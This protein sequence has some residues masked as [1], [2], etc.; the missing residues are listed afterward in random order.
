MKRLEADDS[1]L[2]KSVM[3][4]TGCKIHISEEG[5]MR[6]YRKIGFWGAEEAV[7]KTKRAFEEQLANR[8]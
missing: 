2:I 8:N 3:E 6:E 4:D 5:F 7:V 1:V